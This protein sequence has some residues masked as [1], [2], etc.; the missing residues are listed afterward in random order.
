MFEE[1]TIMDEIDKFFEDNEKNK[2][3]YKLFLNLGISA[4]YTGK[5]IELNNPILKKIKNKTIHI[6]QKR[7]NN[8][9]LF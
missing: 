8:D 1:S 4:E 5:D 2:K 7:K 6:H 3:R 9:N